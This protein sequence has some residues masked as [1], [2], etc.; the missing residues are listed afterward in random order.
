MSTLQL[1][2]PKELYT[3]APDL[4]T[5]AERL[6]NSV[7][8]TEL[9]NTRLTSLRRKNKDTPGISSNNFKT[10]Y[11]EHF[12]I[13]EILKQGR[14]E[15]IPNELKFGRDQFDK[16]ITSIAT[17]RNPQAMM[18]EIFVGKRKITKPETFTVYLE[19]SARDG[20]HKA[21]ELG[22]TLESE[23]VKEL[24]SKF[25]ELSKANGNPN[26]IDLLKADFA[27]QLKDFQH[28]SILKE[29]QRDHERAI[30]RK[31][32]EIDRL[33]DEN[34][35][36]EAQ[37]LESDNELSGAADKINAKIKPPAFQELAIGILYG[38]GKKFAIENPKYL[39]AVTNKSPEEIQKMLTEDSDEAEK[40]NTASGKSDSSASFTDV[41]ADEYEGCTD[42][43]KEKLINLHAFAK[44]LSVEDLDTLYNIFA[45]CCLGDGSINKEN[46]DILI[47]FIKTKIEQ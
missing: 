22:N 16:D 13:T 25:V 19:E 36:L 14:W 24:E 35:D 31:Q 38:I 39:S 34:E 44:A 33:I 3:I 21:A 6:E 17:T 12:R 4:E 7:K 28:Q 11:P 43:Q 10:R 18:I 5:I 1:K 20:S 27:M 30:E 29:L 41:A 8:N 46:A 32:D 2:T 45:F 15:K 47:E 23:K 37:L 40:N 9:E 26:S 42:D